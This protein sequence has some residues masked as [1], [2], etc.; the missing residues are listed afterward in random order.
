MSNGPCTYIS[1]DIFDFGQ[2]AA[3]DSFQ[4]E[5]TVTGQKLEEMELDNGMN[6]DG[7]DTEVGVREEESMAKEMVDKCQVDSARKSGKR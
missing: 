4:K 6:G 3:A 1:V 5:D 7:T 2:K